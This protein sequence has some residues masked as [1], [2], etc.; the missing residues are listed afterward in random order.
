MHY[1]CSRRL[2]LRLSPLVRSA[3][4]DSLGSPAWPCPLL[5]A[6]LR[7][8][9]HAGG[10]VPGI[11]RDRREGGD[12]PGRAA[13]C[14]GRAS[15]SQPRG[16]GPLAV[17]A[18]GG[19]HVASTSGDR[20]VQPSRLPSASTASGSRSMRVVSRR[21]DSRWAPFK[22]KGDAQTSS[23]HATRLPGVISAAGVSSRTWMTGGKTRLRRGNPCRS[24]AC[25]LVP[26]AS[27]S[28]ARGSV[29]CTPVRSHSRTTMT[30]P[31]TRRS[32]SHRRTFLRLSHAARGRE[33]PRRASRQRGPR[34]TGMVGSARLARQ[35]ASADI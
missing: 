6:S 18:D 22:S 7:W 26:G 23:S 16:G 5:V 4:S 13:F 34:R 29:C 11:Y 24:R 28:A 21:R 12:Q 35:A 33:A 10:V 3:G 30:F 17:R 20:G 2:V 31:P 27:A 19:Q 25:R 14:G 9:A 32:F 1:E 15:A 8:A